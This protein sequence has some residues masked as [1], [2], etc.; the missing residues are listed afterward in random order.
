MRYAEKAGNENV[1][2]DAKKQTPLSNSFIGTNRIYL[3]I[4]GVRVLLR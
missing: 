2:H 1:V 4:T 3:M